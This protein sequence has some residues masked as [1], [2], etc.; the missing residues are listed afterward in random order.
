MNLAKGILYFLLIMLV[1][2]LLAALFAPSTKEVR[3]SIK[4]EAPV[5]AVFNQV[6]SFE[7]WK[8]WDVWYQKDPSQKRTYNGSLGDK[9]YGYKW[10]SDNDDVGKG[11]MTIYAVKHGERLDFTFSFGQRTNSGYFTFASKL[12]ITE[13][14][15]VMISELSYPMTILNYFI[16]G[17]VGSDFE[18]GLARLKEYTEKTPLLERLPKDTPVVIVEEYGV[19]YALVKVKDLPTDKLG[20]FLENGYNKVFTHI[21]TNGLVPKGPPHGLFYEWNEKEGTTTLAAAVPVSDVLRELEAQFQVADKTVY[22]GEDYIS[23]TVVGG[24][25]RVYEMHRLLSKWTN[26]NAKSLKTPIVEEYIKGSNDTQDTSQYQTK[27]TY[28]FD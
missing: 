5:D 22:L 20:T 3:R 7:N 9:S 12:G 6:A 26:E 1:A 24:N 10:E 2:G 27:I 13:V 4:I 11:S 21:Q 25:S 8:K 23:S 17:M 18:N 15:W 16:D 28:Y 19:N 14:E